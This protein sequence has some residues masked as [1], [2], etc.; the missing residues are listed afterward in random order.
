MANLLS[1]SYLL[2]TTIA[3]GFLQRY[4]TLSLVNW[5]KNGELSKRGQIY[6][7]DPVILVCFWTEFFELFSIIDVHISAPFS[8]EKMSS[9]M[10]FPFYVR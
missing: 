1:F 5:L 7:E 10:D 8:P 6:M 4:I 2:S 3:Q 9:F